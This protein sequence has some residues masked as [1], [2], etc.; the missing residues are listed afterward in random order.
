MDESLMRRRAAEARVG[1]LAT[2]RADGRPHLVP[3]C[4]VVQGDVVYT[5]VDDVKAKRTPELLRLDNIRRNPDVSFLID[6]YVEDWSA[7]W[8]IRVDGRAHLAEPGSPEQKVATEL[9]AAKYEQYRAEPP[10]G[11]AIAIE[12]T[13]WR[14]WP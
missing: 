1:R 6:D 9:L 4:F 10:S 11:P 12:V 3:C 5:A 13:S 7:L 2:T 8:W 14:A